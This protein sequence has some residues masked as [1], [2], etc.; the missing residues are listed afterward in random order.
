MN[1]LLLNVKIGKAYYFRSC[2]SVYTIDEIPAI[3]SN[4]GTGA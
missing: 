3:F 4:L 2:F 1:M